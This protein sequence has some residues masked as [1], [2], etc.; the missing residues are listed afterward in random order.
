M[1]EI[2]YVTLFPR[3]M[4]EARAIIFNRMFTHSSIVAELIK[5]GCTL[6]SAGFVKWELDG[7]L[8]T[9]GRSESLKLESMEGDE[10]IIMK[11]LT[12]NHGYL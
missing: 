8:F 9:F 3:G 7:K 5:E 11:T 2:K 1:N 4:M 12:G 10:K 6:R